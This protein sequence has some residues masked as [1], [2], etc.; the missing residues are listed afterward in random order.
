MVH[1]AVLAAITFAVDNLRTEDGS[2]L[3]IAAEFTY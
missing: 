2:K 3:F 1:A